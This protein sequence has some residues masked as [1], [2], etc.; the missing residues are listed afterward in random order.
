VFQEEP[1]NVEAWLNRD[2]P[3]ILSFNID[4]ELLAIRFGDQ[5]G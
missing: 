5:Q 2:E 4:Q 1:F 3:G